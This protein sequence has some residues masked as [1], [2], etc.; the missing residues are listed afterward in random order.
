MPIELIA[1]RALRSANNNESELEIWQK[2][3]DESK[4]HK[5][6]VLN[7]YTQG[8]CADKYQRPRS[9]Q[10]QNLKIFKNIKNH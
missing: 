3:E 9:Q 7:K 5:D 1:L 4:P 10:R 8:T 2:N 6:I